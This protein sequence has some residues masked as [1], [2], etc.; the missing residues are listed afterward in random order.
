[1]KTLD[2]LLQRAAVSDDGGSISGLAAVFA[3]PNS[4]NERIAPGAFSATLS[5][6]TARGT[7]PAM[8]LGHDPHAPVG[9]WSRIEEVPEGLAVE[10]TISKATERSREARVLVAEKLVDGLSIGFQA[11][12]STRDDDGM[13]TLTRIELHEISLVSCPAAL[14]ARVRE[15]RSFDSLRD[16]EMALRA[17]LGLSKAAAR[18]VAARGWR[19]ISNA[20]D[21]HDPAEV[22]RLLTT[23][24]RSATSLERFCK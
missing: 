7:V 8:L 5:E 3:T 14:G 17:D 13:R 19:G 12:E 16:L 1:M 21:T 4:Y 22:E 2:F 24:H 15:V 18:A 9:R 11:V 23:I 20:Q 10:G 6:H